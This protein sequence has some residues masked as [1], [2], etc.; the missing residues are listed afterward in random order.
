V[1]DESL[2]HIN[3]DLRSFSDLRNALLTQMAAVEVLLM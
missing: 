2:E 3:V 1:S